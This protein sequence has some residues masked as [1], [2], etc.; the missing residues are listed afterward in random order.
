MSNLMAAVL[1]LCKGS[2]IISF[3]IRGWNEWFYFKNFY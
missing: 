1:W 2:I 3:L